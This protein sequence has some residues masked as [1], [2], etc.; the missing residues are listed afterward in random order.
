MAT[1]DVDAGKV[2]IKNFRRGDTFALT[3]TIKSNA[4]GTVTAINLTGSDFRA[5]LKNK[6][7]GAV[8]HVL[9]YPAGGITAV[10]LV[11]G[12]IKLTVSDTTAWPPGCFIVTD[13]EWTDAGGVVTTPVEFEIQV[14][15]DITY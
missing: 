5:K 3:L 9:E 1:I 10:D 15:A 4:S 7:N 2:Y 12:K 8:L 6:K 13:L 11:A 14:K